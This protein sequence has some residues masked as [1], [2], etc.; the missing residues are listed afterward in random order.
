MDFPGEGKLCT[1]ATRFS[2]V[3]RQKPDPRSQWGCLERPLWGI[4]AVRWIRSWGLGEKEFGEGGLR[5]GAAWRRNAVG[6]EQ[7][8][9]GPC[10]ERHQI[11]SNRASPLPFPR[12]VRRTPFARAWAGEEGDQAGARV[13][14]EAPVRAQAAQQGRGARGCR[15]GLH[16][17][18]AWQ[19]RGSRAR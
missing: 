8:T 15:D 12:P 13:G 7:I 10:T 5:T 1:E 17:L 2:G 16:V 3:L 18:G 9:A 14:E 11:A 6:G 19:G 4:L